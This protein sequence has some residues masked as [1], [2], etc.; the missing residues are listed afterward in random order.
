MVAT[1]RIVAAA[2]TNPSYSP[3][4]TN[5]YLIIVPW[6]HLS[7]HPNWYRDK[8]SHFCWAHGRDQQADRVTDRHTDHTSPSVVISHI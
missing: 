8:F 7:L 5:V 6:A 3:G 2:E 4:G 1:G